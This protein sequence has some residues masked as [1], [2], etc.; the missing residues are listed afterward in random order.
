MGTGGWASGSGE[1]G[2]GEAWRGELWRGEA[3]IWSFS[4]DSPRSRGD[5]VANW[6]KTAK[7][8][9]MNI[10]AELFLWSYFLL[11]FI[12]PNVCLCFPLH[13]SLQ[14]VINQLKSSYVQHMKQLMTIEMLA[15]CR[16]KWRGKHKH[17]FALMKSKKKSD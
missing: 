17:T 8:K 6:E 9:V 1:T 3:G 4:G 12:K 11:L 7:F 5:S 13:M 14:T 10:G 15:V 2:V 16:H